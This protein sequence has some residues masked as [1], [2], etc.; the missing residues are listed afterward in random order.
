MNIYFRAL[1]A[2]WLNVFCTNRE[3]VRSTSDYRVKRLK[4]SS[5]LDFCEI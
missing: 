1:I 4:H 2:A 5:G 3:G